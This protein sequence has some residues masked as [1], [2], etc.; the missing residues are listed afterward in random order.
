MINHRPVNWG[1]FPRLKAWSL[2][3]VS[4]AKAEDRGSNGDYSTGKVSFVKLKVFN[5]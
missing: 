3:N 2:K 4:V 5:D 1:I